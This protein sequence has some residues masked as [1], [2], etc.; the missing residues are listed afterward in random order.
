MTDSTIAHDYAPTRL[1]VFATIL[2]LLI[3]WER[4]AAARVSHI[5]RARRWS[6]NFGMG[7]CD[8]LI[9][10]FIFPAG[11]VSAAVFAAKQHI[12]LLNHM[13][14]A[15]YQAILASCVLLDLTVYLQHRLFHAVPSLWRIHRV[16]HADPE[17]DVSTALRFHPL[18]SVVSMLLKAGM[19]VCCGMP[20]IGVLIFEVILNSAAMFNHTNAS[21]PNR[22][23]PWVRLILVTPSMHSI[24]HSTDHAE[25]N[26]N[27]G[28]SVC[29]WDRLFRSYRA[30]TPIGTSLPGSIGLPDGEA[31]PEHV[32]LHWLLLMPFRE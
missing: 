32:R 17:V 19:V 11:A 7:L 30:P 24:H 27:F 29:W 15:G 10:R 13:P 25:A 23:E 3:L 14:V 9:L 21:I 12:G 5:S 1:I 20:P 16:H 22:A 31:L 8:A 2:A 28:F 18:E 26:R 4:W 6:A